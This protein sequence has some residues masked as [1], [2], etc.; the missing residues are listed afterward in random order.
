MEKNTP[1]VDED[2]SILILMPIGIHLYTSILYELYKK[3]MR[4]CIYWN[5]EK[6]IGLY[7]FPQDLLDRDF[8]L[9]VRDILMLKKMYA[10]DTEV[11]KEGGMGYI[12]RHIS[13]FEGFPYRSLSDVKC[14][15]QTFIHVHS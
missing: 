11:S 6:M 2:G 9:E 1:L 5:E 8:R 12:P 3:R 14:L 15:L 13:L 10:V 4:M 7:L